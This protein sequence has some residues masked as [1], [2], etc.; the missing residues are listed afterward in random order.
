MPISGAVFG[1]V[2]PTPTHNDPDDD[3]EDENGDDF[4]CRD[5]DLNFCKHV[6]RKQVDGK[7]DNDED[8]D[9]ERYVFV[10]VIPVTDE[11]LR[12]EIELSEC[13]VFQLLVGLERKRWMH[14]TDTES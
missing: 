11:K 7:I 1:A 6:D 9:P 2:R 12:V 5:N 13:S 3:D 8:R 4:D 10:L 14:S